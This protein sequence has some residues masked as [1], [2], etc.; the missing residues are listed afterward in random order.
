MTYS[1]QSNNFSNFPSP[2]IQTELIQ[3][4]EQSL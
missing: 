1:G 2:L 3:P 4:N